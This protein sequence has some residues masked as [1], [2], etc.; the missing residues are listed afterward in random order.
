MKIIFSVFL[1]S[2]ASL[3]VHAQESSDDKVLGEII[4]TN[5]EYP[6]GME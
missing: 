5:P 3:S 2:L 1:L 6:G 4:E